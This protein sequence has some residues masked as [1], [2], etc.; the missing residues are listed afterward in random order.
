[1]Q[2]QGAWPGLVWA[3]SRL[4]ASERERGRDR[5]GEGRPKTQ[6][7]DSLKERQEVV[8]EHPINQFLSIKVRAV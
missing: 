3:S 7:A 5:R 2:T 4:P 1:M 8:T 6:P